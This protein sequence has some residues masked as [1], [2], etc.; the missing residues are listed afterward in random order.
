MYKRL[1]DFLEIKNI[2][3]LLQSG[4]WQKH[5]TIH[6]LKK[7][8]E[9]I[10]Q[11]IDKIKYGCGVFIVLKKAFDTVNRSI[12]FKK[13]EHYGVRSTPLEWFQSYLSGKKQYVSVAGNLSEHWKFHAESHRVLCLDHCFFS[14]T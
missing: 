12:L 13:F 6:V 4:F 10:K 2:I 5:S 8:T 7:I 9:K 1:N 14:C 11:T 3:H